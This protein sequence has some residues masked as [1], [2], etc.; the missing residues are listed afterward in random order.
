MLIIGAGGCA[1]DLLAMLQVEDKDVGIHFYDDLNS[2]IPDL[3]YGKHPVLRSVNEA[4]AYFK[5]HDNRCVLGVGNPE[6]RVYLTEKFNSLGGELNSLISEK[7]MIGHNSIIS[8]K[9]VLIMPGV[10]IT[11]EV[12][13]GEG[14]LINMHCTLGHFCKIGKYCDLAPGVYASTSIIGDYCQIGINAVILPRVNIGNNVTIGAGA[15]V[16]KDIP[17]NWIV[18]GLPARKIGENLNISERIKALID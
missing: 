1:K 7:A 16:N 11:T 17:D 2:K 6:T 8:Q 10:I 15:V 13:I 3:L 12:E 4:V 14:S 9:A 5:N 18:A